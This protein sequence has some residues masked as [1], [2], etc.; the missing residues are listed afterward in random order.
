[1]HKGPNGHSTGF[2]ER[3]VGATFL[4]VGIVLLDAPDTFTDDIESLYSVGTQ[5]SGRSGIALAL[6]VSA[7][8]AAQHLHNR[9]RVSSLRRLN[10]FVVRTQTVNRR[11][12]AASR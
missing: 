12:R 10:A 5:F 3:M 6:S 2:L 9:H 8:L 7:Y 11:L 1:M 4:Y